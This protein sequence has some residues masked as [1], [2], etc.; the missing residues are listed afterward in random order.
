M[1]GSIYSTRFLAG[2]GLAS[3]SG[4][5]YP[6]PAG[7][8]AVV[9]TI[10]MNGGGAG[11]EDGLAIIAGVAGFARTKLPAGVAGST[12]NGHVAL[13]AGETLELF[14]VSGPVDMVASGYLLAT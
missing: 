1:A 7:Y 2:S 4:V 14:A 3:G 12:W 13:N 9:R 11:G 5:T 10:T 6:V 8:V